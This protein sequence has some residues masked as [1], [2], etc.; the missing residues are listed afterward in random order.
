VIAIPKASNKAHVRENAQSTDLELTK[1][2]LTEIDRTFPPPKS[3]QPLA[4]L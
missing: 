1:G 3:K 4:M 2:D